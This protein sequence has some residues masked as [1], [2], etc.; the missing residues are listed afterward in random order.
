MTIPEAA[1]L[2][3]YSCYLGRGGEI[4]LFDMGKPVKI[5]NLA[6]KMIKIY[7]NNNNIDIRGLRPW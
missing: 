3:I 5:Y 4:L 1:R 6:K 7:G 2:V